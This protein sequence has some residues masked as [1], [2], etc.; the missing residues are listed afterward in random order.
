MQRA[1]LQLRNFESP[2]WPRVLV[3]RN[4][5]SRVSLSF[6][7]RLIH[8]FSASAEALAR[9]NAVQSVGAAARVFGAHRRFTKT[10]AALHQRRRRPGNLRH[11]V[12]FGYENDA[13]PGAQ[14]DPHREV[15]A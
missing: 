1:V 7:A 5:R 2:V 13:Q 8:Q 15:G 10:I 6:R 14:A 12:R 3:H 11:W 4:H 9:V